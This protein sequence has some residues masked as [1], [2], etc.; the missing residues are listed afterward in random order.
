MAIMQFNQEFVSLDKSSHDL[1]KFDCGKPVMN[2]FLHRYASKNAKLGLS[3]TWVLLDI[4]ATSAKLP[5]VSYFTLSALTVEPSQF[6]ANLP[7]YG[8]PTTLLARLAVDKNYQGQHL[9]VRTLLSALAKAVQLH[10]NGLP[11]YAVIL[12]VLDDEAL[13]FYQ[14]FEFFQQLPSLDGKMQL[15]VPMTVLEAF[16]Q[17]I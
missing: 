10:Q 9:G 13:A 7:R 4:G 3:K 17:S 12:D 15:F 6:T 14:K 11:S 16:L 8:V 2:E 1:K 5:I